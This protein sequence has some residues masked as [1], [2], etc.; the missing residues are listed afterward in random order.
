[1]AQFSTVCGGA[2]SDLHVDT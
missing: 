1:M 2:Y